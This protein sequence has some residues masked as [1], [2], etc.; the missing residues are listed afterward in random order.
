MEDVLVAIKIIGLVV[1]FNLVYVFSLRM[2]RNYK[3]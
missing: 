1:I 2:A 3:K